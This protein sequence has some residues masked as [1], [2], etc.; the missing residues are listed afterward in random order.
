MSWGKGFGCSEETVALETHPKTL[1]YPK[2]KFSNKILD[3]VG[4]E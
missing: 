4:P 1:A 2:G 3:I